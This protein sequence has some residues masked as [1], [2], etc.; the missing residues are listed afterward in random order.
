MISNSFKESLSLQQEDHPEPVLQTGVAF[1][2]ERIREINKD[3]QAQ[4]TPTTKQNNEPSEEV[5]R[6]NSQIFQ[7]Q[8]LI[9]E[10]NELIQRIQEEVGYTDLG[11]YLEVIRLFKQV[12][13]HCKSN[14]F[15]YREVDG[16]KERIDSEQLVAHVD[17]LIRNLKKGFQCLNKTPQKKSRENTENDFESQHSGEFRLNIVHTETPI[18]KGGETA[19][20]KQ[21]KTLR[22]NF[23]FE[24][25]ELT[26]DVDQI[27]EQRNDPKDA[28]ESEKDFEAKESLES[29]KKRES[30]TKVIY[31][32]SLEQQL[33]SG[34]KS[35]KLELTDNKEKVTLVENDSR[36]SQERKKELYQNLFYKES[37]QTDLATSE[38]NIIESQFEWTYDK[39]CPSLHTSEFEE[40]R[41]EL[42]TIPDNK[43]GLKH[44]T[45]MQIESKRFIEDSQQMRSEAFSNFRGMHLLSKPSCEDSIPEVRSGV[46]EGGVGQK[47]P[48]PGSRGKKPL[49]NFSFNVPRGSRDWKTIDESFVNIAK[50]TQNS[51]NNVFKEN[52]ES[53]IT[54]EY[55]KDSSLKK[56]RYIRES[57]K[58]DN[59]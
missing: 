53:F 59:F 20:V 44:S 49:E 9:F 52:V 17:T 22:N 25:P 23:T 14:G 31:I 54:S 4:L 43:D 38:S 34:K 15:F 18:V 51:K 3:S 47:K 21:K 16:K 46:K 36:P 40:S 45:L 48:E 33:S 50:T 12:M 26:N 29:P 37:K 24:V 41:R 32:C 58:P 57:I 6:L 56:D 10:K 13:A 5:V 42:S 28:K 8:K 30:G 2:V 55:G 7:L 39:N 11:E 19:N 1:H 35:Y 27:L